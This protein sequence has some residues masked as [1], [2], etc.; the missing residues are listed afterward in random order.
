MYLNSQKIWVLTSALVILIMF[1]TFVYAQG[2]ESALG[3]AGGFNK[4]EESEPS[5]NN[6]QS[7][8][9]FSGQ[10]GS[11]DEFVFYE[12]Q[13]RAQVEISC[14]K[15]A[16][17]MMSLTPPQRILDMSTSARTQRALSLFE[18][19]I[20]KQHLEAMEYAYDIY[21][22]INPIERAL[23][24]NADTVRANELLDQM[25]SKNYSGGLARQAQ[26]FILNPEYLLSLEKK[27]IACKNLKLLSGNS[28][29]TAKTKEIIDDL[30]ASI[31]CKLLR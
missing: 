14:I 4:K 29:L 31:V 23:N 1:S 13:C 7:Q 9:L 18:I 15:A 10:I 12:K 28:G 30:N 25:L 26:D 16:Q 27:S 11:Y 8:Q 22:I 20:N 19:A 17:I 6:N 3:K 5:K 2:I 21:Y 24:P